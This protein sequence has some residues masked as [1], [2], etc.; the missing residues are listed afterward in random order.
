[1]TL[2]EVF[3][4]CSPGPTTSCSR[5]PLEREVR[6]LKPCPRNAN[7]VLRGVYA[8]VFSHRSKTKNIHDEHSSTGRIA[9]LSPNEI[10]NREMSTKGIN[11]TRKEQND[12]IRKR[13]T[14]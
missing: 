2:C 5:V 11:K 12:M 1:V 4:L 14:N 13:P 10:R 7:A 6:L 8:I 9:D 3:Q